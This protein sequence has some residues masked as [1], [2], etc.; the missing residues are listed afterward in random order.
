MANARFDLRNEARR[1]LYAY[2]GVADR[3]V[4]IVRGGVTDVQKR[5]V[6]VQASV[7]DI[8]FE[9]AA[10]RAQL[11]KEARA[12]RAAFAKEAQARR[13]AIEARV[14]ELRGRAL[15]LI[16]ETEETYDGLVTRGE[17]L[18][19][20]IRRQQSTQAA[21]TSARTTSAKAKTTRT[22]SGKAARSTA[23]TAK[24]TTKTAAKSTANAASSQSRRPRSSAKA[25]STAAKKTAANTAKATSD[26]AKKVGD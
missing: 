11:V 17:V 22:Q 25:T 2:V 4:E 24:R 15:E 16:G 26:A 3:A 7:Q 12:R 8:D 18:V 13:N 20:R 6:G 23:G 19:G 14:R 9:P 21:A 1:P 5:L 10:L